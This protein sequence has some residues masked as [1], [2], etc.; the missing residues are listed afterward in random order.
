[1][2]LRQRRLIVY[3]DPVADSYRTAQTFQSFEVVSSMAFPDKLIA[4]ADILG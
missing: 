3:R 1:V 2:D 4:V